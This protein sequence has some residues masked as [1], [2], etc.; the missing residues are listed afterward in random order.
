MSK[1]SVQQ[2]R[3]QRLSRPPSQRWRAFLQNHRPQRWAT[4]LFTVQTLTF[5]TLYVLLL[6]AHE[7][8]ELLHLNVT[9]HPT[10]AW[11]WRQLVDATPW[12]RAPRFLLRDRDR[13]YGGDVVRRAKRRGIETLLTPVCAPRANAVAERVIGTRRRACLDHLVILNAQHLGAV[14][15][16]LVRSYNSERPHRTLRL[17]TPQPVARSTTGPIRMRPVLG[18][19]HHTYERAA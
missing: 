10:A 13:V 17:E 7:R 11:V 15:A 3:G 14:V 5:K 4:G 19:L 1:R 2:Y 16:E 6:I 9:A 12:G 8:R 18:G